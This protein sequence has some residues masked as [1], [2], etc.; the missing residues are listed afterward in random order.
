MVV[1]VL[2]MGMEVP[3]VEGEDIAREGEDVDLGRGWGYQDVHYKGNGGT[4]G[5]VGGALDRSCRSG[6]LCWVHINKGLLQP[7]CVRMDPGIRC[8]QRQEREQMKSLNNQSA[9]FIDKVQRLE[10]RNRELV[11]KWDLL[12]K[13]VMPPQKNLKQVFESFICSLKRQLDLLLQER[14]QRK[15]EQNDMEKLVEELKCKCEQEVSRHTAAKKQFMLLK[16]DVDC[17]YLTKA[18]L[19]VK[20]ENLKREIELLKCV[21]A[22]ETAE[23]ERSLCDASVIVKMDNSRGL[24]VEGILKSI[25][26]WYEDL[27]QKSKAELD[28]LYRTRYQE[29]EEA[30]GRR[31]HELKSHQQEV[32]ELS[33]VMQRRQCDLDNMKKQVSSLQTSIYATENHRDCA[34]KDAREK[35]V[36]LQN[37]LQKAKDELACMLRDYQ[38]LLN[39]KRALG[40]EIATYKTLLEGE[41]SR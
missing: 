36:E 33:L 30:K 35:H 34:L 21:F 11:T 19:D 7:L 31:Y 26:C 13:Q 8:I 24:A 12:Q 38:E 16:K 15:L 6:G 10:Q 1:K 2:V 17:D 9:F 29:L 18:E 22:Q 5:S 40:I 4:C 27:A 20:L 3:Y 28:A 25:E 39:V 23:L 41:E 37:A 32:E 14:R